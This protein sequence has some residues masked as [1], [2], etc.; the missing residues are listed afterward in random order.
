MLNTFLACVPD[1]HTLSLSSPDSCL[2]VSGG[3]HAQDKERVLRLLFAKINQSQ[4]GMP[5]PGGGAGP[6][7]EP[8][9]PEEYGDALDGLDDVASTGGSI[10][11]T[12]GN[13]G[14]AYPGSSSLNRPAFA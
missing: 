10:G 14:W 3:V 12:R 9:Q 5:G 6:P 4:M 8:E 1:T 11:G 2:S 13:S 7:M